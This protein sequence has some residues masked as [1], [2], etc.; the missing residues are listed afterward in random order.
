MFDSKSNYQRIG[1]LLFNLGGPET[2]EDVRPFLFNIFVDPDI[3]RLPWRAL[4]KPL[5]WLISTQRHKKSRGYYEQIGGGSPLRRITEEQ[6][7]AL[8][9]TLAARNI[10]ARA[11]VGM[12]YWNPFIEE[13]LD[14][15][16]RDQIDHLVV[17]PLYP[18]FSVST[19]GSS[20]N[21]MHAIAAETGHRL[22]PMSV[23]CSY[24]ADADYVAA[25]A[26]AASEE[27][28]RFPDQDPSKT[29]ILF[30]AHSVP[31]KYIDDGDPYLD[32]TKRTV[33][34]VMDR[35][36]VSRPHTLSFQSKVGPVEW[37]TPATNETIPRLA[38]EGVS[39]LLLVPVSFVSEHSETLYE[40]DIL[41]RGVADE[42]GI[43]HFRRVPTM[44]CRPAFI[45]ALASL[46]E[47]ALPSRAGDESRSN[48]IHSPEAAA[49]ALCACDRAD[50]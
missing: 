27:L 18:Q 22:P 1:I 2:L 25:M 46:V 31:V 49:A 20:L 12:R 5:A 9:Q 44:N 34:L 38:R 39:Q 41:Y 36:G 23:V 50:R 42:A 17:L 4:Q 35:L 45:E 6:A 40:M 43:A 26:A 37:L 48:C 8:E 24:E 13:A 19:T 16:R 11:Y 21:R 14:Q 15:I 47:R 3:I 10:N 7:R 33:E 28:A 29:H 30:S 32:H